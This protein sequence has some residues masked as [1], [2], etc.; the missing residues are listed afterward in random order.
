MRALGAELR[1]APALKTDAGRF[2]CAVQAPDGAAA[3]RDIDLQVRSEPHFLGYIIRVNMTPC[4]C[5]YYFVPQVLRKFR[6]LCFPR[7]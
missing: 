2:A 1:L 3:R 5:Y 7:S 6:P 4:Y